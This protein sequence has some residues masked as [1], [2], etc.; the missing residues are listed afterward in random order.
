MKVKV[1]LKGIFKSLLV[2]TVES[3]I[4]KAYFKFISSIICSS[5]Y[6]PNN[7]LI[8]YEIN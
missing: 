3:L 2:N 4:P 6:I 8:E 5:Q 7:F 1:R